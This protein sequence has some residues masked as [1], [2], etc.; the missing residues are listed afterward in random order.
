MHWGCLSQAPAL[1]SL[2]AALGARAGLAARGSLH[3]PPTPRWRKPREHSG[4]RSQ[5]GPGGG[6]GVP[7]ATQSGQLQ[8]PEGT[9]AR[10]GVTQCVW[11]PLPQPPSHSTT[12][13][14][15]VLQ[16]AHANSRVGSSSSSASS[17]RTLGAPNLL[18][19][20][21]GASLPYAAAVSRAATATASCSSISAVGTRWSASCR[22]SRAS[23][24]I[25]QSPR[26]HHQCSRP[27]EARS[28]HWQTGLMPIQLGGG[29]S[30]RAHRADAHHHLRR[31]HAAGS[32]Q[33]HIGGGAGGGRSDGTSNGGSSAWNLRPTRMRAASSL[34]ASGVPTSHIQ[35]ATAMTLATL[36]AWT[37][38]SA[39]CREMSSC[40]SCR[41]GEDVAASAAHWQ[42]EGAAETELVVASTFAP[43]PR[44]PFREAA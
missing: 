44:R 19:V 8:S 10:R 27:H 12:S 34:S 22:R 33:W 42:R 1:P 5:G 6:F 16:M 32:P 35:T 29:S 11:K 13:P 43:H 21:S 39:T 3:G 26:A 28:P 2:G 24:R 38:S 41:S 15:P 36:A 40:G 37:C 20:S 30:S 7:A 4:F 31:A 18:E 25:A 17:V 9:P 23:R 14:P